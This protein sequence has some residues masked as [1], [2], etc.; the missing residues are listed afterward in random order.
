MAINDIPAL[1]LEHDVLLDM[2]VSSKPFIRLKLRPWHWETKSD[3]T[4]SSKPIQPLPKPKTSVYVPDR[5]EGPTDLIAIDS[6]NSDHEI[7]EALFNYNKNTVDELPILKG[8]TIHVFA[9]SQDG[10]CYGV[11]QRTKQSGLFP[12][13][14]VFK[15]RL[16]VRSS[17]VY[18][19]LQSYQNT[20]KDPLYDALQ[21]PSTPGSLYEQISSG[22]TPQSATRNQSFTFHDPNATYSTVK[23]PH[24]LSHQ[25]DAINEDVALNEDASVYHVAAV[26]NGY[27]RVNHEGSS[28]NLLEVGSPDSN[29]RTSILQFGGEDIYAKI[30]TDHDPPPIPERK[31]DK[32]LLPTILFNRQTLILQ[33]KGD[34]ASDDGQDED[35]YESMYDVLPELSR[36]GSS[37]ACIPDHSITTITVAQAN[38]IPPA[39]SSRPLVVLSAPPGLAALTSVSSTSIDVSQMDPKQRKEHEKRVKEERKRAE[40]E[41][42]L[43]AKQEKDA[44]KLLEKEQKLLAKKQKADDE[45]LR[46]L[47]K[48]T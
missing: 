47:A 42:K 14:F 23:K 32:K 11:N 33:D 8:D 5:V 24:P 31:Y 21:A 1:E 26:D 12:G 36:K 3:G 9:K 30:V 20:S 16:V 35:N 4:V 43:Q 37:P 25:L 7:V 15:K 10:W 22:N 2:I 29:T 6:E 34:N 18:D 19:E 40:K 46:K 27:A 48:A 13:N 38:N 17:G 41:L 44:K 45:R 28:P 39:L